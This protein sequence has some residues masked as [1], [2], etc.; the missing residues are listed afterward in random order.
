MDRAAVLML[1]TLLLAPSL[2]Q[3][4]GPLHR[5]DDSCPP[6][7]PSTCAS[8]NCPAG[9]FL[10]GPCTCCPS[11]A[12]EEGSSCF[13]K[14]IQ[15]LPPPPPG[16]VIAP[17]GEN[18]ECLLRKDLHPRD[19]PEA[20]CTCKQK[21][22]VCGTNDLTYENICQLR[23]AAVRGNYRGG[24][25]ATKNWGRCKSLPEI[26]GPPDDTYGPLSNELALGCEAKGNPIPDVHWEFRPEN[27]ANK[28]NLPS[29]DQSVSV[30]VR[31]G[32]DS[33]MVTSWV[34]IINL[35]VNYTGTYTC[36]ATNE[37]GTT[38]AD[39]KVGVYTP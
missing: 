9:E 37:I 14:S 15:A 23:E 7:D 13:N 27:H 10:P 2:A 20:L 29:D 35:Q 26:T 6:C 5:P 38:R 28:R 3:R 17:C 31:G 39:A 11:C 33:Y 22:A 4:G 1:A 36:V 32:P 24:A 18:L 8:K 30:Q 25:L 34:Q 16:K 21:E 12:L 19:V